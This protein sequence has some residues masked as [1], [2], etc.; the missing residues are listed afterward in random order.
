MRAEKF[1]KP[2]DDLQTDLIVVTLY[3]NERPPRGVH[4]LID[5]RLHGFISRAILSGTV[6]G[7]ENESV[8]M[9]LGRKLPARRLLVLGLGKKETYDLARARHTAY[10]LGKTV[11][12]LCANDVAVF[13]PPAIDERIFGETERSVL[14]SMEQADLPKDLYVRWLDPT[15]AEQ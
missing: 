14:S 12:Q 5:W 1:T 4:G 10:R 7:V 9:P 11:A 15:V 6:A 8:L 2:L 3:E 13:F